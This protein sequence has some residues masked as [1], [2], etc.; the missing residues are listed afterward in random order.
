M[1]AY[2]RQARN[3][4]LEVDAAEIR[5]RAERRLGELISAQ[6]AGEG[7]A[8][9]KR[10]DLVPERNQVDRPTLAGRGVVGRDRARTHQ[11]QRRA[12]RDHVA[13][14]G[15]HCLELPGNPWEYVAP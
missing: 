11:D 9:G 13:W 14:S 2:A 3:K 5:I 4:Q 7:L 8:Q 15:R 12:C 6:K 1:R 10:T